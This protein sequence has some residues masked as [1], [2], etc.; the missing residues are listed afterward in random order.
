MSPENFCYW[1]QGYFELTRESP[2]FDMSQVEEIKNHL[3]LVLTKVTPS[4]SIPYVGTSIPPTQPFTVTCSTDTTQTS[5][6]CAPSTSLAQLGQSF[7]INNIKYCSSQGSTLNP[8]R[9]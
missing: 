4:Y 8:N 5:G 1:L 9:N 3:K 6:Y 2:G 7:D